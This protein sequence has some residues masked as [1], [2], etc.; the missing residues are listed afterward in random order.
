MVG[1]KM[2]YKLY[3]KG[4]STQGRFEQWDRKNHATKAAALAKYKADTAGYK[5]KSW[6]KKD[7]PQIQ[8]RSVPKKNTGYSLRPFGFKF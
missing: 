1:E 6:H 2:A 5:S 7:N 4:T 3:Y 8:V